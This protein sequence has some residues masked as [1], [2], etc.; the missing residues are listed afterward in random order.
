MWTDLISARLRRRITGGL[1]DGVVV[2]RSKRARRL[3]LRLDQKNRVFNLVVP[4]G[5]SMR[6][7]E[8]FALNNLDWIED[9]LDALPAPVY[10]EDGALLPI[11]G[12]RHRI[13][14]YCDETLKT[15]TILLNNNELNALTNKEDPGPRIARFLKKIARD[16]LEELSHEKA[17]LIRRKVRSVKVRD[18]RS[19]WGSCSEDG[20]LSY[21]W[22]LMFAPPAAFDYVVAHEI[23]HLR[24][25]DHGK[26]FWELCRELSEDFIEG[27]DWIRLHGHELMRYGG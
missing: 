2:Q 21:S 27:Q 1:P 25:M 8:V 11:F 13:R 20:N 3:A 26:K 12:K 4:H 24:H 6:K 7:A 14:A 5:M 10:F 17:A 22:R 19:R 23:A 16:R 18:T 9:K 15:T